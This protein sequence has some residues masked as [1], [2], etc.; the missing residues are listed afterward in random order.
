MSYSGQVQGISKVATGVAAAFARSVKGKLTVDGKP[1]EEYGA[2]GQVVVGKGTLDISL[3]ITDAVGMAAA[4][5]AKWF[6]T[7]AGV[8]VAAFPDFL[9]TT[10]GQ[11][12]TLEDGQPGPA[13]FSMAAG[14]GLFKGSFNAKFATANPTAAAIAHAYNELAG[15]TNNTITVQLGAADIGCLSF[16]L[17]NGMD[18]PPMVNPMDTKVAGS[19]S[20]PKGYQIAAKLPTVSAVLEAELDTDEL[21]ADAW[22]PADLVIDCGEFGTITVKDVVQASLEGEVTDGSS[23]VGYAYKFQLGSGTV[24]NRVQFS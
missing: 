10:G 13:S 16:E 2:G 19:L 7:T 20:L 17:G 15:D 3:D 21:F 18:A 8:Q 23:V 4:D 14:D 6:P 9:C 5:V 22:T 11:Q 24:Y 1:I 12:W